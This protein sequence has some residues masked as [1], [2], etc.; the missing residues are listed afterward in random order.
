MVVKKLADGEL[1]ALILDVFW[2]RDGALTPGD[3]HEALAGTHDVGYSTI[4][5]VLSRLR[6][7][8]LLDRT[9]VSRSYA[10]RPVMSQADQTAAR[11]Q[12]VLS[13]AGDPAVALSRFVDVLAPKER[14]ELRKALLGNR[15]TR[16]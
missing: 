9:K 4:T 14:E 10:Y 5:T 1:E 13:A 15:P 12:D 8:G 16:Q 7:K 11:M 3:V 2:Q 6:G